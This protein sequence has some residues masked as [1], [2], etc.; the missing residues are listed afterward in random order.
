[1]KQVDYTGKPRYSTVKKY[2]DPSIKEVTFEP[3]KV[4]KEIKFSEPTL[5]E[6]FDQYGNIVKRGYD[7]VI[8]C[9]NLK[10]GVYYLNYDNKTGETFVKK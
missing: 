5:F 2:R 9:S 6:I 7:G 10:K 1:M 3:K 8:D 4:S